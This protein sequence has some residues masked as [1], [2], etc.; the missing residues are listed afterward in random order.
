MCEGPPSYLQ[1]K[2]WWAA[3]CLQSRTAGHIHVRSMS[4]Y[5]I[6][7]RMRIFQPQVEEKFKQTFYV[8]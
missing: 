2:M 5:S 8:K 7:L 4:G 3:D 6:P 1:R